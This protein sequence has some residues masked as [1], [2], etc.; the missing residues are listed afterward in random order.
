MVVVVGIND[1]EVGFSSIFFCS[2][3]SFLLFVGGGNW[4]QGGGGG[5]HPKP[6]C[7]GK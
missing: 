2:T 4:Q 5:G 3:W 1:L 7:G 6:R